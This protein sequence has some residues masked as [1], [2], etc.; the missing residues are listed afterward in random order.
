MATVHP[1]Q[2]SIKDCFQTHYSLPYFQRE[3][4]W[5]PRHL[6]EF[7]SDIQESF[8]EN[9]DAAHGRAAVSKYSQYF[10]GSIITAPIEDGKVPL[11]DGQQRLTSS[12]ILLA[13]LSRYVQDRDIPQ[14]A[15]LN[16]LLGSMNYGEID[17][18][19]EFTP[20]RKEIFYKYLSK[21]INGEDALKSAEDVTE[22]DESD[23]KILEALRSIDS[24]LDKPVLD[25]LP[26]FVDYILE[27]V[28]LIDI[29]VGSESD[30]HKV[31]VSMNDRG[32][33]LGPIDLLK[34][35]ILSKIDLPDEARSCNQVW[36][37][38]VSKLQSTEP[39]ADSVFIRTLFRSQWADSIRGKTKGDPSGDF[40]QIGDAYHR[41]FQD[42]TAKLK[43][44]N[45]DNYKDF[46]KITISKFSEIYS[47][48]KSAEQTLT[49]NHEEIFY[50]AARRFSLQPMVLLACVKQDDI[51][52]TWKKKISLT[53]KLI[54]LVLTS[55]SIE[56]KQN[57]YDNLKEIS[58][59]LTKE[60]RHLSV[61][62]LEKY[63]TNEWEKHHKTL[64]SLKDVKY[65]KA[66]RSDILYYFAR[67]SCYIEENLDPANGIGFTNYWQRDKGGKTFDIEHLLRKTFDAKYLPK[68]H[69]FADAK[70]YDEK[71]NLLGA[72]T[73]LPRSRNRSL[74]DDSYRSK[75]GVYATENTLAKSFCEEFYKNNP[76]LDRFL[77]EH[78]QFDLMAISEFKSEHIE[79]RAKTYVEI[80]RKIWECPIP[81]AKEGIE[82]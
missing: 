77:A 6:E 62:D 69:G 70:E 51:E 10:L 81:L 39:E 30:A 76:R 37:N 26:Y 29:S 75:L 38:K 50:N 68:E 53:S 54:D 23:K 35:Q 8:L 67:I 66:D 19:I 60:I 9:F 7:I 58:F 31:F 28:C 4:K 34:G 56:G 48:I 22:I 73:L 49:K 13:Y 32:L 52:E 44:T 47:F 17:F 80:A 65:T 3:Y 78:P 71:R 36:I 2:K 46:I 74:Q 41:W 72:L 1:Q 79:R 14:V 33:R 43:L 42:N 59:Q 21:E 11:I 24:L 45:G 18:T 5:E 55:R 64:E 20:K 82:E 12:F 25:A 40:D 15:D 27:K 16:N 61:E 63:I 57:N